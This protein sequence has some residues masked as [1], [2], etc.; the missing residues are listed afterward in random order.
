MYNSITEEVIRN[1]PQIDGSETD[2]LPQYLTEVYARIVSVRRRLDDSKRVDQKL[3]SDIAELRKLANNLESM[4]V[5]NLKNTNQ[6]S[7]AFV[8][9]TAH[10]LLQL[11]RN[12]DNLVHELT[13][14]NVPSWM[15]SILLFL[16][17]ESPTDAAE[18]AEKVSLFK[19]ENIKDQLSISIRYLARGQLDL[20]KAVQPITKTYSEIDNNIEAEDYLWLQLLLGLQHMSKVLLGRTSSKYNFF[21]EVIELSASNISYGDDIVTSCYSGP[22]HLALLLNTL[23]ESLLRRG[24][25]NVVPPKGTDHE[26]WYSFLQK[27]A[28]SRPY[29]WENHFEAI[30]TGFLD[31]GNSAVLTFPTGAG[32]TT[33]AELKIASTIIS[34]RSVLYLV[35]TH[36]LEDQ[37]NRDLRKL[38]DNLHLDMLE[39]GGEFTDIE[40]QKLL[41]INVMTPERCLTLLAMN[42]EN[43][44]KVGLVVFDEFHLVNGREDRIDRRSL[45]AMYCLLRLFAEIPDSDYL[46]MSAMVE[47]GEEIAEWVSKITGRN[48]EAFNSTWKPT[49]QLQGCVLYP[50]NELDDLKKIIR[51]AHLK[52]LKG[53]PP[54]AIAEQIVATPYQI[55]SLRNIW[56]SSRPNNFFMGKILDKKIKLGLNK[57]WKITSNR[58]QVAAELA[59]FF[60]NSGIKTL[61][62]VDNPVVA[63]STSKTLNAL[64]DKRE[65]DF[66]AFSIQNSKQIFSLSLELGDLKFSFF[67]MENNVAAHHGLLLPVERQL[68]ELLFKSK[69][70]IHAIVATATLAQGINLPA[71]VVIIAG[72]DRF[73][74]DTDL[75]EKLLAHEILNASGRAGRAGTA[76]H[77]VV[78]IVPGSNIEFDNRSE[79]PEAWKDLQKQ[80]FS[81]NDQC[82]TINDPLTRFLDE[83]TKSD[84]DDFFSQDVNSLL[85]RLNSEDTENTSIKTIFNKSFAAFKAE[86]NGNNTFY[87]QLNRL[88]RVRDGLALELLYSEL[89]ENVSLKTGIQPN[90]IEQLG[91]SLD[92]IDLNEL[93]EYSVSQWI[94]WFLKWLKGSEIRTTE[95]FPNSAAQ[96]QLARVLGL[97]VSKY[98]ISEVSEKIMDI[99]PI[100]TAFIRGENYNTINEMIPGKSDDYLT[101]ARHFVL[102]LVPQFSYAIGAVSLTLKEKLQLLDYDIDD[103]PF[104]IRNL[105]TMVKEGMDTKEKLLYK[106]ENRG[107]LRVQIHDSFLL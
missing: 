30:Q 45:D 106:I 89:V 17:G 95:M 42:P 74:E 47:N 16:I 13:S 94:N 12:Q 35:P 52:K 55:F 78:I 69:D 81:K 60:V 76:A 101:K 38:F 6:V 36:A 73:D 50:T 100:L 7:A 49:R 32:K 18:V 15:S 20:L 39:L 31:S 104:V 77:G 64:L 103:I 1:A 44:H 85:L 80:V 68:N 63:K 33:I 92:E 72:D 87:E 48:C 21:K 2:N 14:Q 65:F 54:Q 26:K 29:L 67:N 91:N 59:S 88:T 97:K 19:I 71:E 66:S 83:V 107:L 24:I 8:S 28:A 10:H 40:N 99:E 82:L 41:T 70:G 51:E 98:E 90:I 58:N 46:L 56:D 79:A 57:N 93:L 75:R 96:A 43:F 37:I 61:V 105:A 4:T 5:L 53:G 23:Q 86:K 22:Y 84:Q 3:I 34:E 27:M 9:G 102:R 62:F 11:I 25:I